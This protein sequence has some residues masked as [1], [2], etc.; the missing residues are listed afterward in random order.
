MRMGHERAVFSGSGFP[1]RPGFTLLE[2]VLVL[3]ILTVLGA[4]AAPRFASAGARYRVDLAARRIAADLHLAQRAARSTGSATVLTF[5]TVN[6]RYQITGIDA[7]DGSGS[8][9]VDL[10][11][12]PYQSTL[13]S[14][15]FGSGSVLTFDGWGVPDV[16]GVLTL[17][18]GAETRT[19]S[20]D[21]PS[22]RATVQ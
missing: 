21:H 18:A 20:L 7:L 9:Q 3:G 5:D 6:H 4:V 1:F 12:S 22:G 15:V 17:V 13:S 14:A 10:A 11:A 16:N 19:V 8:Y 2:L